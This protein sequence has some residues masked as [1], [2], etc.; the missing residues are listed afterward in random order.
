MERYR[1]YLIQKGGIRYLDPD[2]RSL[3][4]DRHRAELFTQKEWEAWGQEQEFEREPIGEDEAM[5]LIGA[6]ELPGLEV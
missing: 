6:P 4:P 1:F 3:I 5:R 2:R